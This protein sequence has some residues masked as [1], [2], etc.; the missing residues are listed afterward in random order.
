MLFSFRLVRKINR[1]VSSVSHA[2][3]YS[4]LACTVG[5]CIHLCLVI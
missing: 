5:M 2:T 3:R 4:I 1:D